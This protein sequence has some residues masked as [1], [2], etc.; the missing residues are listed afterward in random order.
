MRRFQKKVDNRWPK[1]RNWEWKVLGHSMKNCVEEVCGRKMIGG[2]RRKGFKWWNESVEM[3]V[4]EEK[5]LY[6][7]Y[8]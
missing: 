3:H 8:L 5:E 2:V 1:K 7:K 4:K 6:E